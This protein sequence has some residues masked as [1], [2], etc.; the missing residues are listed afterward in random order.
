MIFTDHSL[1]QP[2]TRRKANGIDEVQATL[3][4]SGMLLANTTVLASQDLLRRKIFSVTGDVRSRQ[5]RKSWKYRVRG[6]Q[7][8]ASVPQEAPS[9]VQHPLLKI[10]LRNNAYK[11]RQ[12][13]VC[14][15]NSSHAAF[16]LEQAKGHPLIIDLRKTCVVS[17]VS[18][19]GRHPLTRKYP[20]VSYTHD[21]GWVVE[22]RPDWNPKERYKGPFYTVLAPA[23]PN[24]PKATHVEQFVHK[25][26]LQWRSDGSHCWHSLGTFRGNSDC[27][28]EV[29]HILERH[30]AVSKGGLICRYLRVLP[31]DSSGGGAMRVGV[32][33]CSRDE[34]PQPRCSSCEPDTDSNDDSPA[35]I[36]YTLRTSA[37]ERFNQHFCNDGSGHQRCRCTYCLPKRWTHT[38]RTEVRRQAREEGHDVRRAFGVVK[39]MLE[40]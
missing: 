34:A 23:S 27:C 18:T 12:D 4:A 19:Q 28:T 32:Y 15:H 38:R 24:D 6:L 37:T 5:R 39:A 25:Y 31:L 26:E 1:V 11:V 2:I 21:E 40:K 36:T 20:H 8:Y 35:S 3:E 9:D 13:A 10:S 22:G 14:R 17:A 7:L 16:S 30:P 33:G 29:A